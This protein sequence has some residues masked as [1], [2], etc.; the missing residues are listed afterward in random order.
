M[1]KKTVFHESWL[2][3]SDYSAW[4]GKHV[5]KHKAQ[6]KICLK[7]RIFSRET[8]GVEALKSHAGGAKH[9][10]K[11]K[12]REHHTCFHHYCIYV[13][14]HASIMRAHTSDKYNTISLLDFSHFV[15]RG[16]Q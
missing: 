11:L 4:L 6:C 2:K 15:F 16:I 12:A 13:F 9:E 14:V 1:N 3:K 10:S 5:S 8:C 7:E